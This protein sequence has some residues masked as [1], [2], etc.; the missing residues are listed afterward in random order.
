M[1]PL[2]LRSRNSPTLDH[3]AYDHIQTAVSKRAATLAPV[4]RADPP[5]AVCNPIHR[6]LPD[7][8]PVYEV[9]AE[10]AQLAPFWQTRPLQWILP[11][12]GFRKVRVDDP[13]DTTGD[14]EEDGQGYIGHAW[15]LWI[16]ANTAPCI[17]DSVIAW[18]L[19]WHGIWVLDNETEGRPVTVDIQDLAWNPD[20]SLDHWLQIGNARSITVHL[21]GHPFGTLP[22]LARPVL[23]HAP[24]EFIL[25]HDAATPHAFTPD[26]PY[27]FI[28]LFDGA[29]DGFA[30]SFHG[31]SWWDYITEDDLSFWLLAQRI[32]DQAEAVWAP[33]RYAAQQA[34]AR[35]DRI[36]NCL[37]KLQAAAETFVFVTAATPEWAPVLD[38]TQ[39]LLTALAAFTPPGS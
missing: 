13:L 7:I 38:A 28:Y 22:W 6:A 26:F 34:Q 1:P 17:N 24:A 32:H 25:T 27:P 37:S 8:S 11:A 20:D 30:A 14:W 18:N 5:G 35:A 23:P 12:A 39:A 10:A 3:F 4:Y 16:R 29:A 19:R 2:P 15:E 21:D 36:R 31:V 9:L 33:D